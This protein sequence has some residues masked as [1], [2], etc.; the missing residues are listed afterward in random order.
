MLVG[1]RR[2]LLLALAAAVA[3]CSGTAAGGNAN[4]TLGGSAAVVGTAGVRSNPTLLDP[5]ATA[6]LDSAPQVA[7]GRE[8]FQKLAVRP[9]PDSSAFLINF[10]SNGPAQSGVP[11]INCVSGAETHDNVGLTGPSSYVTTGSTWQ[12]TLSF[13]DLT[14]KGSC[15]LAWAIT[16]GKKTIDSFSATVKLASA[17]GFVLYAVDRGRPS[18]SGAATLSGKVT[19]GS[20]SQMLQVPIEFE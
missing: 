3:G 16:S 4:P 14:Y 10:V 18:Y 2:G 8:A 12:Y 5:T 15:K 19:C 9:N 1:A 17:G 13:S 6:A 11:C 7:G 20:G